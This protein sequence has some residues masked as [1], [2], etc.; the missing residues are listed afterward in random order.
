MKQVQDGNL[1]VVDLMWLDGRVER[2]GR[3]LL[4]VHPPNH[5]V[6]WNTQ[7]GTKVWK[8][9]YNETL[10]G[11]DVDPFNPFRIMFRCQS[12]V[13]FIEDFHPEKCPKS[14][15]KKFY[16]VAGKGG[17]AA[18]RR[19]TADSA[20]S[21]PGGGDE[22]ST[23]GTKLS[24]IMRQMVLGETKQSSS[25]VDTCADCLSA[26]FHKGVRNLIVLSFPK[27]V[28]LVD[29]KLSQVLGT[30]NL[31][32]VHSPLAGIRTGTEKDVL[33]ILHESGSVSVWSRKQNLA[34]LATPSISRSTS[35]VG[36]PRTPLSSALGE[37]G[38]GLAG[39][40]VILEISYES[41]VKL[42]PF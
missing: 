26:I 40:D 42:L 9:S 32:R 21:V 7:T 24:K 27:E 12:C 36:L 38:Y 25:A 28:L 17:G 16:I 6:L 22:K 8:H 18:G 3:L 15:G 13:I 31:E 37:D 20:L 14:E 35:M 4:A 11:L 41:K 39:S 19:G 29:T 10:Y 1:P 30:I 2:T 34:V 23:K 33:F 5:L